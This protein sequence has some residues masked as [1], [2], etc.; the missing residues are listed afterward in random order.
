MDCDIRPA[1]PE[2][3]DAIWHIFREVVRSGD[4]FAYTEATTREEALALWMGRDTRAWMAVCDGAIAGT[5]FV[6]PNQPGR[7]SHVANA[8]FMVTATVR[9]RGVGRSMALDALRQAK[10]LGYR[11]MQFNF[12][13]SSNSA[14]VRLWQAI[15]F[16]IVG[17]LPAAFDDAVQGYVDVYVMSRPLD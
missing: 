4:A 11:A 13:V 1:T 5:Y 3:A 10:T 6:R 12:V 14:A 2:D 15:C 17:T 7:G 9:G 16:A 8:G